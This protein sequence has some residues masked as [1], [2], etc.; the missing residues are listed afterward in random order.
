M[1]RKSVVVPDIGPVELVKNSRN[2]HIRLTVSVKVV[3]VSL[4]IWTSYSA[5]IRFVESQKQ[6][7][8]TEQNKQVTVTLREGDKIGKLHTLHFKTVPKSTRPTARTTATKLTVMRYA[9][10][11]I[12]SPAV[13]LRAEKAAI[14]ALRKEAEVVLPNRI[15]SL[16]AIHNLTYSS[17]AIR[18]LK[19]RWGSCDSHKAIVINL[20]TMQLSWQQID[21]V[22]CHELAHTVHMNHGSEFWRLLES[23]LPDAR[24][25][26]KAVRHTQP[27]IMPR[28][29]SDTYEDD[30]AY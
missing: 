10:E 16:A 3:R 21:Y 28:Q 14:R 22:L 13:Q 20:Y 19:R 12:E 6:W 9:D 5:G 17:L 15:R 30:M 7:V 26:A 2:R 27:T 8:H 23:M 24:M 1:H 4:P 11:P 29:T 25:V 18:Q